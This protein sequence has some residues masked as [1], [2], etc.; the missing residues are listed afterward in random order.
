MSSE[1]ITL[2][3]AVALAE[4]G[5][6]PLLSML[7]FAL[8]L[9]NWGQQLQGADGVRSNF[10]VVLLIVHVAVGTVGDWF[11]FLFGFCNISIVLKIMA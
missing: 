4:T 11:V 2:A 3:V 1:A 8:L 9:W 6:G 7:L 10:V 5:S